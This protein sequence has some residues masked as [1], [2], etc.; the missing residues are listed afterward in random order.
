MQVQATSMLLSELEFSDQPKDLLH[1][2]LT[3]NSQISTNSSLARRMQMAESNEEMQIFRQIGIGSCGVV[4]EQTGCA[5]VVKRGLGERMPLWRDYVMH[6]AVQE[7]LEKHPLAAIRIPRCLAFINSENR[8]WWDANGHYFPEQYE[9]PADLLL[10]ERIPPLPRIVRDALI[11]MYL[12]ER[13]AAKRE[14]VRAYPANKDCLTRLYLGRRRDPTR[15]P[16]MLFTLRNFMLHIDQIEELQLDANT[17]ATT[18]AD[19][20]AVLH[21]EAKVDGD[22]IEFVLGS[23]PTPIYNQVTRL[24][25]LKKLPAYTDTLGARSGTNF[26]RRSVFMWVLDFNQCHEISVDQTGVQQAVRAFDKN[27]TYYPRPL[28]QNSHDQQ[29]WKL[30]QDRYLATSEQSL[31][32]ECTW[33]AVLFIEMLVKERQNVLEAKGSSAVH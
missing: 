30:F 1:R 18:M 24:E 11:D 33:L 6:T 8:S 16:S 10:S 3:I 13:L 19:T 23:A 2:M 31:G 7:G 26:Q 12:P 21:W 22:D 15:R 20:L 28:A 5:H 4:F 14:E 9:R 27:E 25:E 32:K 17:F 29:L